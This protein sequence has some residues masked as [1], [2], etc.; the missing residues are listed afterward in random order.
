MAIDKAGARRVIEGA[1][2]SF[3]QVTAK[4]PDQLREWLRKNV[5]G[6]AIQ[7]LEELVLESRPPVIYL[8]GRS[9]HGKSS[10]LNTLAGREVAKVGAVRPQTSGADAY[11]ITFE[12]PPAEWMLVDTRGIFETPTVEGAGFDPIEQTLQDFRK[13]RPDVILHVLAAPEVRAS[14][15]DFEVFER[16]QRAA[17]KE[18]GGPL[19]TVLVLTKV[20]VL[21]D[22]DEWPL[23]EHPRKAAQVKEL[24]DYVA[25][26]I[27][28][29]QPEPIDPNST[30]KGYRLTGGNYV[31]VI[32]V[33]VAG[34]RRWNVE[35]LEDFVGSYLPRSAVL[36]Y[37]QGLRR[38][39]LLRR[40]S[41]QV[42]RRFAAISSGIGATPVPFADIAVLTPLQV[43]LVAIIAGLS[44]RTFSLDAAAELSAATGV[45]VGFA[46]AAREGARA[47]LRFAPGVGSLSSAAIA[48]ATTYGIGK[49]AEAY[50]FSGEVRR[51]WS[52]LR[53]W[54]RGSGSEEAWEE[55]PDERSGPE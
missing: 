11:F 39:E 25:R 35:T 26:D 29:G 47:A 9:G 50:F 38:R 2:S 15:N 55:G 1:N 8:L 33:S 36:D 51:P 43:L 5:L 32:P 19:P 54:R 52:F 12:N 17:A 21:G 18:F 14:S 7:E 4:L 42:T 48:G 6:A 45:N 41:T 27:L 46:F 3:D 10:L 34:E 28:G 22:P 13:H 37:A 23:A 40:V 30:L 20:D 44:C 53:E 31:G 49:S 16:I 24:L